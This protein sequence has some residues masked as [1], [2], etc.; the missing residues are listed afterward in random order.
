MGPPPGGAQKVVKEKK[1]GQPG[2]RNVAE[3]RK[4]RGRSSHST[5]SPWL[6]GQHA[7]RHAVSGCGAAAVQRPAWSLAEG[8]VGERPRGKEGGPCFLGVPD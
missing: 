1:E 4:W 7:A 2:R 3:Q 8:R 5:W 6:L